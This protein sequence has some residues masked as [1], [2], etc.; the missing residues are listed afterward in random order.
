MPA[1]TLRLGAAIALFVSLTGSSAAMAEMHARA[2]TA[3]IEEGA[4]TPTSAQR[5]TVGVYP[6]VVDDLNIAASTYDVVAYVWFRWKGP[7]DPTVGL[8]FTN[9]SERQNFVAQKLYPEP[10]KLADGSLYQLMQIHGRFFQPFSLIDFPFDRQTLAI[11]MEDEINGHHRIVYVPDLRDSGFSAALQVPGWRTLGWHAEAT[12]QDYA[13]HFGAPE[14]AGSTRHA[15]L[16]FAIIIERRASFFLWKLFLPLLIVMC[17]N[18]LAFLIKPDLVDVRTALTA[19]S[20]LTL[21]FLQ[22]S[23]S[24]ELPEVGTLVLMDKIYAVAYLLVI[25]TLAH[26]VAMA[27]WQKRSNVSDSRVM[28]VDWTSLGIHVAFFAATVTIILLGVER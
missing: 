18:W 7:I 8:E 24:D 25:A 9:V 1:W 19:T 26:V 15:G 28:K 27:S 23:Y 16:R 4:A 21:V 10:H 22:K 6:T 12:L 14:V 13:S 3:A 2:P 20:L 17:A 5:V 11:N